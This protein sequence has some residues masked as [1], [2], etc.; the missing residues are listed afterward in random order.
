[1]RIRTYGGRAAPVVALVA[2]TLA[3]TGCGQTDAEAPEATPG[4][5]GQSTTRPPVPEGARVGAPD[6]ACDMPVTFALAESWKPKAVTVAPDNPL[7]ELAR[8]GPLTMVC[9]IDAKPAGNIGFLRVWT[10]A[11]DQLRASLEAFVGTDAHQPTYTDLRVGDRPALEVV[12]QEKSQL[13]DEMEPERV[14]AVQTARG[15]TAV[16]LDSFGSDEHTAMLPAYELAKS[17]LRQRD[18]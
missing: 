4:T 10:G 9:E 18:S 2:S 17:S 5:A 3:L 13:D 8:R 15:I 12:Y 16:S 6:S 1:M 14:F 7:A 11:G